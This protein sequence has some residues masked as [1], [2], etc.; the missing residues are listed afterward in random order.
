MRLNPMSIGRKRF[1]LRTA[2]ALVVASI[3]ATALAQER[4][5]LLSA[6]PDDVLLVVDG[7]HNPERQFIED[8]WREVQQAFEKSGVV[9][10][11]I[12]LVFT[13]L[14]EDQQSE[15]NRVLERFTELVKAVDWHG[16]G[17][18]EV[19]FTERMM[20]P[21]RTNS[22]L[23][24]GPPDMVVLFRGD[25]AIAGKNYAGLTALLDA[26]V[27][28][29][30]KAAGV[31]LKTERT[32]RGAAELATFDVTQSVP[33]A[34]RIPITVGR[35]GD[36]L[37]ISLGTKLRDD[38][39][40]LL[41]GGKSVKPIADN[42][43]FKNAFKSLHAPEDAI[44][45]FDMAHLRTAIRAIAD[46][47]LAEVAASAAD[48]VEHGHQST[49]VTT[50][51]QQGYAAYEAG[52]Y[53]EA[54]SI[55]EKA[56]GLDAKDSVVL[57][58]LACMHALLKHKE[59]ALDWLDKAVD[60]GFYSPAKISQDSD[61]ASL[62]NEPRFQKAVERARQQ[63]GAGGMGGANPWPALVSRLVGCMAI[64]DY[65]ASVEYTEG[66]STH[67]DAFTALPA[68]AARN[69]LYPVVTS[70]E[71]IKDF[72]QF[73]P[74]ETETFSVSGGV[75]L[76][77]LYKFVE[78]TFKEA[79]E[80]GEQ[81]WQA[82]A[83]IQRQYK[84][85]I[86]KDLIDWLDGACVSA[87]FKQGTDDAWFAMIKVKDDAAARAKVDWLLEFLPETLTD[88]AAQNPALAMFR[89]MIQPTGNA[90]LAG[91]HDVSFVML[92]KP[93][94]CG[95]RAGWIILASSQDAALTVLATGGG[96][97]PN[98]RQNPAL[99]AELLVPAGSVQ[100]ISFSDHRHDAEQIAAV[101]TGVSMAGGMISAFVPEPKA[102]KAIFKAF[103]IIA[104]LGPV[105]AKINFYKSSASYT[106]FD[107][108]AWTTHSVMHYVSPKDRVAAAPASP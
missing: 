95:V 81:A 93:M 105:A 9:K 59:P 88:L 40:D 57:Y 67:T 55:F 12:E 75:S 79:G 71:P 13:H 10:D 91:F 19:A 49:E 51:N 39:L 101:L 41:A 29:I 72:A 42:P 63:A 80:P 56:H 54:L 99:M 103:E 108:S 11:A 35:S 83:E 23:T 94:V 102:Q 3:G 89:P 6:I 30:N 45:F 25:P 96:K 22:G 46:V 48:R 5:T 14:T 33:Q 27:D 82:W 76:P 16:L 92:P 44:T 32:K 70:S 74:K 73:L 98:V 21:Q 34:P 66:Y 85:D 43:R 7:R 106:E 90:E 64:I 28:E 104:K 53:D 38:V 17:A 15:A 78:D 4:F 37:L 69:P 61:L 8:Y 20:T 24:M 1:P 60:G 31:T 36:V 47:A 84:F 68:D 77:A 50:L 2:V 86:R 107:G 26:G 52:K 58:N 18:G 62:R 100:A 65:V 97:H 87:S